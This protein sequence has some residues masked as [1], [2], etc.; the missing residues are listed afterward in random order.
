MF[1]KALNELTDERAEVLA[2]ARELQKAAAD[3][4]TM[5]DELETLT[6]ELAVLLE[7]IQD[8]IDENAHTAQ[9]QEEYARHHNELVSRYRFW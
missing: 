9:D 3:T 8:N 1:L 6:A 2:N 4:A 7:R 5:Q